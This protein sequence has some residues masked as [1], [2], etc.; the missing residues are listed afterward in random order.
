[1]KKV[2]Y[3]IIKYRACFKCIKN[4]K[5]NYDC[6][7]YG[8]NIEDLKTQIKEKEKSEKVENI[9]FFK[10]ISNGDPYYGCM[11]ELHNIT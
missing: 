9:R 6:I 4:D 5:T 7:I 11:R 2:K 3:K 10:F 1:M 8:V